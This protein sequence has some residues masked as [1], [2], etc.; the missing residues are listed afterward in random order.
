MYSQNKEKKKKIN[1]DLVIVASQWL[2]EVVYDNRA[3]IQS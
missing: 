2:K 3:I 1:I